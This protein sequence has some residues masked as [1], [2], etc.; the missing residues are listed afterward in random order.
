M[1]YF[2][3]FCEHLILLVIQPNRSSAAAPAS[4]AHTYRLLIVKELVWYFCCMLTKRFVCLPRRRKSMK[5]LAHFVNFYF[6]NIVVSGDPFL[7]RFA[8]LLIGEANYSKARLVWQGLA[9]KT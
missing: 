8:A 2:I 6:Y 7:S 1:S 5:R 3:S 9:G 4:N